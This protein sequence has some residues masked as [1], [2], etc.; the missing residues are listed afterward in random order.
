M[1]KQSRDVS[2]FVLSRPLCIFAS[3]SW[4]TQ[5]ASL[6]NSL[7]AALSFSY[8]SQLKPLILCLSAGFMLSWTRLYSSLS[9]GLLHSLSLSSSSTH[10]ISCSATSQIPFPPFFPFCWIF[11]PRQ[12]KRGSE[13][14]WSRHFKLCMLR[15]AGQYSP[16]RFLACHSN[17]LLDPLSNIQ[18][19]CRMSGF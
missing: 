12:E 11:S 4:L 10:F 1:R 9:S 7:P 6:Y 14:V 3:V 19:P 13:R 8:L 5:I 17:L 15:Q 18:T 16:S 2:F